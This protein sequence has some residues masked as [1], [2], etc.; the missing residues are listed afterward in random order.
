L[1]TDL[2][3]VNFPNLT[4]LICV[5]K[6]SILD[7]S[8]KNIVWYWIKEHPNVAEWSKAP[9]WE[10]RF[11]ILGLIPCQAR[12][13]STPYFKETNKAPTLNVIVIYSN[14]LKMI[15]LSNYCLSRY[16]NRWLLL[17]NVGMVEKLNWLGCRQPN[18]LCPHRPGK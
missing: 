12:N 5:R 17:L 8:F 16:F 4:M 13:F 1:H 15:T 6:Y 18:N 9:D 14:S 7:S 10:R 3:N 11:E 2:T